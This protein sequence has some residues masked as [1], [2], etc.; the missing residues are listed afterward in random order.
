MDVVV[1]VAIFIGYSGSLWSW[2]LQPKLRSA[3]STKETDQLSTPFVDPLI[4]DRR[5][6]IF[7]TS[8]VHHYYGIFK[9]K[10]ASLP[11]LSWIK[12]L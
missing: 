3:L 6:A 2:D 10:G 1:V 12:I 7:F 4:P 11:R 8:T 9:Y 5:D